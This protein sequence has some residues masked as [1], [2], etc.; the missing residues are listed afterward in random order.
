MVVLAVPTGGGS[1]AV[2]TAVTGAAA[3]LAAAGLG[4]AAGLARSAYDDLV[5]QVSTT[6][7]FMQKRV[8]YRHDLG[9]L[10]TAMKFSLPASSDV[11]DQVTMVRDAWASSLQEI[12]YKVGELDATNLASGPWLRDPEMAV[13]AANWIKVDDAMRAFVGGT[14]IDSNLLPFANALPKDDP[15]W[16]KNLLQQIAA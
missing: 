10:D 2:G 6:S 12:K 8:C 14:F 5:K 9:A 3:G 16:Q 11:I 1:F 13:S 7:D 4:T 15:N